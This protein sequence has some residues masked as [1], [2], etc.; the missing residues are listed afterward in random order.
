[1]FKKYKR[2]ISLF[3]MLIMASFGL[4]TSIMYMQGNKLVFAQDNTSGSLPESNPE[5]TSMPESSGEIETSISE[6]IPERET[7][8]ESSSADES[9]ETGNSE[10][11]GT[12]HEASNVETPDL[13]NIPYLPFVKNIFAS[14]GEAD[15]FIQLIKEDPDAQNQ[16][17]IEKKPVGS[18]DGYMVTLNYA[19]DASEGKRYILFYARAE[20]SSI[21]EAYQLGNEIM[22][23]YP[24]L[25]FDYEPWM[26]SDGVYDLILGIRY[27]VNT[28]DIDFNERLHR[29]TYKGA[30]LPHTYTIERDENGEF[31]DK[32][33][34]I[35]EAQTRPSHDFTE[36]IDEAQ[37][38]KTVT[39]TPI[40]YT[41]E[42]LSS[43]SNDSNN[44]ESED[45]SVTSL[46]QVSL[47]P[48]SSSSLDRVTSS[49][50][51]ESKE[52][53]LFGFLPYSGDLSN[54]V[55]LAVSAIVFIVGLIILITSVRK[56]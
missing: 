19:D 35:I 54:L 30:R 8:E 32:I 12:S 28:P 24:D 39:I 6:S 37:G 2:V 34:S 3:T 53:K 45:E 47:I 46:R 44:S 25:F 11:R 55:L 13:L 40:D 50:V 33:R 4:Q 22:N 38:I 31:P 20:L 7:S 48:V 18:G 49:L 29:L 36:T 43:V 10:H 1:M 26:V 15:T 23:T 21:D 42:S 9:E 56:T 41:A 51:F 52:D 16:F 27:Q 5:S 14:Q 17:K